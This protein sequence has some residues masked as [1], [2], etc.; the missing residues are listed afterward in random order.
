[1]TSFLHE[2]CTQHQNL[3]TQRKQLFLPRLCFCGSKTDSTSLMYHRRQIETESC[4]DLSTAAV[5]KALAVGAVVTADNS[6]AQQLCQMTS[7]RALG[8]AVQPLGKP[9]V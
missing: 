3:V 1:M 8:H 7:Q 2:R 5:G 4:G 9:L 6:R